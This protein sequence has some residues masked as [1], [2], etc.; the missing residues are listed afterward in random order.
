[1]EGEV[2]CGLEA[3]N[4]NADGAGVSEGDRLRLRG[5]AYLGGGEGEGALR[6]GV[7]DEW[8]GVAG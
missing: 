2:R 6:C 4:V 8:G 1:L 7:G 5:V 3:G